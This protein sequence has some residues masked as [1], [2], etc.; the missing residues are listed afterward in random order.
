LLCLLA[1]RGILRLRSGFRVG[2]QRH[3][4][5]AFRELSHNADVHSQSPP[6]PLLIVLPAPA[7]V[8]AAFSPLSKT[9]FTFERPVKSDTDV[10]KNVRAWDVVSG[11]EVAGWHQKT[12]DD[13]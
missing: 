2:L 5:P 11:E 12:F 4:L 7:A 6:H 13:W 10:H 8:A 9:L 3:L 1:Q